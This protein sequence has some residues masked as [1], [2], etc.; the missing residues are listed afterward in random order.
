MAFRKISAKERI[1]INVKSEYAGVYEDFKEFANI[2][3]LK[4]GNSKKTSG[5]ADS[6]ARYFI[7][8]IILYKD[9][10][11]DKLENIVSEEVS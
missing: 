3:T 7:K 6:Y 2:Q 1:F 4:A 10:F 11:L 8:L 5:K 9:F